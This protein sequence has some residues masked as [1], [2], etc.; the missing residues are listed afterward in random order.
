V[1][2]RD[3]LALCEQVLD[4]LLAV[5]DLLLLLL[6]RLV[7]DELATLTGLTAKLW[8]SVRTIR[9]GGTS[10]FEVCESRVQVGRGAVKSR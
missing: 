5:V 3:L 6:E 9:E 7:V 1:A 2:P 8:V 10:V 4:L